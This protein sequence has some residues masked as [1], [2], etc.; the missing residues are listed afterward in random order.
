M[1]TDKYSSLKEL[2]FSPATEATTEIHNRSKCK[3]PLVSWYKQNITPIYL[4]LRE[5]H[6]RRDRKIIRARGQRHQLDT[7]GYSFMTS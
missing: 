4:S 7:A 2:F 1:S 3:E 6:G 5:H